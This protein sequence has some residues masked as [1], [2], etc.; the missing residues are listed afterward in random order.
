MKKIYLL[1]VLFLF[2][3]GTPQA[4]SQELASLLRPDTIAVVHLNLKDFDF[5]RFTESKVERIDSFFENLNYDEDS[6][7]AIC[8]EAKTLITS[9]LNLV[10]PFYQ[11][12]VMA[13]KLDE[14]YLISYADGLETVP[15]IVATPLEGKSKAQIALLESFFANAPI[16]PFH[17]D[18]FLILAVPCLPDKG[19]QAAEW[20][21]THL[22]SGHHHH[23]AVVEAF[24]NMSEDTI[25]RVIVIKPENLQEL[26]DGVDLSCIPPQAMAV[27]NMVL[28]KFQW[29][30]FGLD[31]YAH[32][33]ELTVQTSSEEDAEELW[34]LLKATQDMGIEMLR[35]GL[36]GGI[37]MGAEDNPALLL[38]MEYIPLLTEIARGAIRQTLPEIDGTKL[39]FSCQ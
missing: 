10:R 39:I 22:E 21:K 14:V 15:V 31:V 23:S 13:T 2:T 16:K 11:M 1:I 5:D 28:E 7:E 3:L 37:T 18:D 9:K 12:F 38:F 32:S 25:F 20:V 36:Y 34:E 30:S 4:F 33:V 6:R 27:L 35:I 29:I 26:L 17:Q 8:R 24:D 19:E